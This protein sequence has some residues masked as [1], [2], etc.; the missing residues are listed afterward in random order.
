MKVSCKAIIIRQTLFLAASSLIAFL[1]A[2]YESGMLTEEEGTVKRL[3]SDGSFIS[4]ILFLSFGIF[5]FISHWGGFDSFGY[6]MAKL[7]H[8]T[9]GSYFDYVRERHA[10]KKIPSV[11]FLTTG[12]VMLLVAV[13]ALI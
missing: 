5:L 8:K 13:I 4:A 6:V 2:L 9:K 10:G 12:A 7:K 11:M 1:I 3:I